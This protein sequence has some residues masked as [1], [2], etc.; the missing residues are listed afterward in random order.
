MQLNILNF[1]PVRM[2]LCQ[3]KQADLLFQH[4]CSIYFFYIFK[5]DYIPNILAVF[6]SQFL[7]SEAPPNLGRR[8]ISCLDVGGGGGGVRRRISA[9]WLG[10]AWNL[11]HTICWCRQMCGPKTMKYDGRLS[12]KTSRGDNWSAV[13]NGHLPVQCPHMGYYEKKHKTHLKIRQRQTIER[14]LPRFC[15]HSIHYTRK[16]SAKDGNSYT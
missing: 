5:R 8:S 14:Y 15:L 2:K 7:G 11:H 6:T 9:N 12:E 10:F 1:M 13:I 3:S 16:S 4:H